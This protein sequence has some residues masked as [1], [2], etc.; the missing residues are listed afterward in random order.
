LIDTWEAQDAGC[1]QPTAAGLA[2]SAWRHHAG[3]VMPTVDH[4]EPHTSMARDAY[5]SGLIQAYYVGPVRPTD[6]TYGKKEFERLVDLPSRPRC[7]VHLVDVC[8]AYSHVMAENYFPMRFLKMQHDVDVKKFLMLCD[9]W[10]PIA[11]VLVD[12]HDTAYP[13]RRQ[14]ELRWAT[15]CFWTTLCGPELIPAVEAGHVRRILACAWYLPGRPFGGFIEHWWK[16]QGQAEKDANPAFAQLCKLIRNSLTGKLGQRECR[17][18]DAPGK[19]CPQRWGEWTMIN[20]Q[21]K[22][23][24]HC[25]ALAGHRQEKSHHGEGRHSTPQIAA[26]INSYARKRLGEFIQ[27][28]GVENVLYVH[29]DALLVTTPGLNNLEKYDL[30]GNRVLGKLEKRW[31]ADTCTIYG[32]AD[33]V[34]DGQVVKSGVKVTPDTKPAGPFEQL[35]FQSLESV[36][37]HKPRRSIMVTPVTITRGRHD[38]TRRV[39]PNGW[40]TPIEKIEP[41]AMPF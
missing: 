35:S 33:Y 17:W 36:L 18:R 20:A 1:F 10:L 32:P 8:G 41:D 34:H 11:R 3:S 29:T 37:A 30:L 7:P 9:C 6:G 21:T 16:L 5:Y 28:A 12:S 23:V 27:A 38:Q 39:L 15:G 40:T 31:S 26:Y 25:R 24:T 19:P 22:E 13:W 4:S 14:E 2:W